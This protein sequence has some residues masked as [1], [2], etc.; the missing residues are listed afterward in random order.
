MVS[1][2]ADMVGQD[3][4]NYAIGGR[5]RPEP[6]AAVAVAIEMPHGAVVEMMLEDGFAVLPSI[7]SN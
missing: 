6:R 7:P 3:R 5:R 4:R 2:S 1:G